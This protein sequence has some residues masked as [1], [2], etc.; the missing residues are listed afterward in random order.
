[1]YVFDQ[2]KIKAYLQAN[3]GYAFYEA[4]RSPY[5]G[6]YN[7][8]G[9]NPMFKWIAKKIDEWNTKSSLNIIF[10]RN[11]DRR[12]RLM[13]IHHL[14]LNEKWT[15]ELDDQYEAFVAHENAIMRKWKK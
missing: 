4:L 15:Q 9:M 2:Q 5:D 14:Q 1:M 7:I 12:I 11:I 13:E 10:D 3:G 8:K 6:Y